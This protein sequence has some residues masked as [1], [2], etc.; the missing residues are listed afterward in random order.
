MKRNRG[1]TLIESVIALAVILIV[2]SGVFFGLSPTSRAY[3]AL[4]RTSRELRSNLQYV[5]RKA[6]MEGT[7]Y[8]IEF[9]TRNNSY[10]VIKARTPFTATQFNRD[11]NIIHFADG[12]SFVSTSRSHRIIYTARGT[13][14]GGTTITLASGPFRQEVRILVTS[15]R[16]NVRDIIREVRG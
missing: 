14:D 12:V 11:D 1:L 9:D 16:V 10:V 8:G 3:R 13:V 5:Q 4:D 2:S 15:G 7:R 6:I